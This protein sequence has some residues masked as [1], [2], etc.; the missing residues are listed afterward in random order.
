MY[1]PDKIWMVVELMF[2]IVFEEILL[3][4]GKYQ[5]CR[6][7]LPLN[8]WKMIF[9]S[10]GCNVRS[11]WMGSERYPRTFGDVGSKSVK[12]YTEF[13]KLTEDVTAR[14]GDVIGLLNG[15]IAELPNGNTFKGVSRPL[16]YILIFK[17][18]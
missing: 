7:I 14:E 16:L 17:K 6:L 2:G 5:F 18:D 9:L 1:I 8:W 13:G 11:T 12:L 10:L 3:T 4:S 15:D